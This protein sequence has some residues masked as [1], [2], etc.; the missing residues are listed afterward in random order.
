M[1]IQLPCRHQAAWR[2]AGST[3]PSPPPP[4]LTGSSMSNPLSHRSVHVAT[5]ALALAVPVRAPQTAQPAIV[6][7][8][9]VGGI[10]A[11]RIPGNGLRV[12]FSPDPTKAQ[13]LVNLTYLVGSRHEGYGETGMAHLLEHMLFKGTT[14]HTDIVRELE[15]HGAAYTG[16][17]PF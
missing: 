10:I 17:R 13:T 1:A 9:S 14:R 8:G 6:R 16:T 11:Y 15:S 4:A 12:L 3:A 5:L 2:A 7:E